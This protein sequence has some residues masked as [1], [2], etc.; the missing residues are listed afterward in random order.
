MGKKNVTADASGIFAVQLVS[1]EIEVKNWGTKKVCDAGNLPKRL[2][3]T[4]K[5]FEQAQHMRNKC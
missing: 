4:L 5:L 2:K 3:K 1:S